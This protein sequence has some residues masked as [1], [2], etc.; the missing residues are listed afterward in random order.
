[1]VPQ[2]SALAG[3]EVGGR[4]GVY[5]R[6]SD[7]NSRCSRTDSYT[8]HI[9]TVHDRVFRRRDLI[10]YKSSSISSCGTLGKGSADN[11]NSERLTGISFSFRGW[12]CDN[13]L[14]SALENQAD[15]YQLRGINLAGLTR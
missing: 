7:I 14:G 15:I 6:Y 8:L 9:K 13:M 2:R 1:M 5:K 11:Q 4:A 12:S 10:G 3:S